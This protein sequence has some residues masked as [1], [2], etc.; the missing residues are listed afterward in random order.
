M[1]RHSKNLKFKRKKS[2]IRKEIHETHT[3]TERRHRVGE[4]VIT[5]AG[6]ILSVFLT[7]LGYFELVALVVAFL[8]S[9]FPLASML[10]IAIVDILLFNNYDAAEIN[11]RKRLVFMEAWNRA[12]LKRDKMITYLVLGALVKGGDEAAEE[13]S[14]EM[15]DYVLSGEGD[16]VDAME[17][18]SSKQLNED[19]SLPGRFKRF[20]RR[21]L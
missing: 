5:V 1:I 3:E 2:K 9:I 20:V 13:L 7:A 15:M 14:E 4:L 18:M 19:I 17:V 12:V 6:G 8:V 10:R 21:L 11:I 16:L